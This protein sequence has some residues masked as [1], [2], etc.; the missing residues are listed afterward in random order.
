MSANLNQFI[1]GGMLCRNS[2]EGDA[3]A[4]C[5]GHCI[6]ITIAIILETMCGTKAIMKFFQTTA[7]TSID[8]VRIGNIIIGLRKIGSFN[9]HFD[10]VL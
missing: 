5:Q 9:Y 7:M 10:T 6:D 1:H 2:V 8:A 3:A 4:I